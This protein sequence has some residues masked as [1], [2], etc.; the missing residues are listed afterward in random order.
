LAAV[1]EVAALILLVLVVAALGVIV[2]LP[3]C[4]LV[5]VL[6]TQL[7]LARGVMAQQQKHLT[8]ATELHLRLTAF[9]PVVVAEAVRITAVLLLVLE[10]QVAAVLTQA[11]GLV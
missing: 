4:L 6:R 7:L 8:V 1:V 11:L 5:L 2:L 9:R 10:A 3:V